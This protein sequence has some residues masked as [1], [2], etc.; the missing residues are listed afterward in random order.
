M[1]NPKKSKYLQLNKEQK[2]AICGFKKD[3]PKITLANLARHFE[4]VFELDT[5]SLKIS[6][7]NGVLKNSDQ[8]LNATNP[9]K[10]RDR[11]AANPELEDGLY[12]W[13]CNMRSNFVAINDSMIIE[14][15]LEL[16]TPEF[17]GA[18]NCNFTNGWLQKFKS[19]LN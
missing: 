13:F 6:T 14:K 18:L 9:R 17:F 11:K 4:R 15:A 10:F 5:F 12:L 19:R 7:L 16:A 3:H 2:V 1:E 8:I